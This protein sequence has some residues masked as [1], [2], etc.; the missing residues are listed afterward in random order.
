MQKVYCV[1][2]KLF[3]LL[4]T[5]DIGARIVRRTISSQI[6]GHCCLTPLGSIQRG[7]QRQMLP[8]QPNIIHAPL[9]KVRVHFK[10]PDSC[11]FSF[12]TSIHSL[13][14]VDGHHLVP[15]EDERVVVTSSLASIECED[16]D[17][18]VPLDLDRVPLA[19]VDKNGRQPDLF[20]LGAKGVQVVP[21]TEFAVLN[22]ERN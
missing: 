8:F 10:S 12:A 20:L 16:G 4:W 14:L 7:G 2:L 17:W 18:A 15:G 11:I 21:E 19:V 5:N 3:N 13:L 22:L 6:S 1:G 9:G